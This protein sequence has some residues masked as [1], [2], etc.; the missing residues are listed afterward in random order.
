[1][2]RCSYSP[3]A[4]RSTTYNEIAEVYLTGCVSSVPGGSTHSADETLSVSV[5][6]WA[7]L[8]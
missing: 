4:L 5:L 2:N 3:S 1:M 6:F 7:S 8:R